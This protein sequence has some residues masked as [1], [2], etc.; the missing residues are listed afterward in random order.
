MRANGNEVLAQELHKP[1]LKSL[2]EG[3]LYQVQRYLGSRLS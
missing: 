1:L 3:I 2:K